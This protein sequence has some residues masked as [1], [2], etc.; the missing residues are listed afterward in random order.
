MFKLAYGQ[1]AARNYGSLQ[2]LP[3]RF[4]PRRFRP[5]LFFRLFS[6]DQ[7]LSARSRF[8]CAR[9][10]GS[11]GNL[12]PRGGKMDEGLSHN[13]VTSAGGIKACKGFGFK[14]LPP[15]LFPASDPNYR[16]LRMDVLVM[17]I[18]EENVARR[19]TK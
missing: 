8:Y 7:V 11:E 4:L 16:S 18:A 1:R 12:R 6:V 13:V 3:S 9:T 15:S 17:G 19:G 14:S 5:L 2:D 10:P